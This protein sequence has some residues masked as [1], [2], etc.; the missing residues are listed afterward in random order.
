MNDLPDLRPG[1]EPVAEILARRRSSCAIPVFVKVRIDAD[2]LLANRQTSDDEPQL[3]IWWLKMPNGREIRAH[4]VTW[5]AL[6]VSKYER[7][8]TLWSSTDRVRAW[9]EVHGP[10]IADGA[11]YDPNEEK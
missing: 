10:V 4:R 3:P 2:A 5:G 8:G 11:L 7:R 6:T 9:L 1:E